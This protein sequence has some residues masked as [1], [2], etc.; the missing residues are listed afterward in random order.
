MEGM[1]VLT[2]DIHSDAR[3]FFMETYHDERYQKCGVQEV[4]VQ[5]NHSHS[6]QNVIRGL[7]FQYSAPTAK[8]IRVAY[9]TIFAVGVDIRPSSSTFGKWEGIE[10]SS[11]N[12]RQLYL[13]FGF[14]FGFCAI[15]K[16]AGVLYKLSAVHDEQGSGTIRWDD[17]D[18]GIVWP[19]T[20]PIV[21]P[22]DAAAPTLKEMI[23][24]GT[25][26]R[27]RPASSE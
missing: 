26:E 19:T 6:V 10:L 1:L 5:D 17:S 15:S 2:P 20:T 18:I 8:L 3:G 13:P 23:A 25:I 14:A 7:K 21:S 12:K 16:E 11:E 22:A 27:M 9:G 24:G 4:F